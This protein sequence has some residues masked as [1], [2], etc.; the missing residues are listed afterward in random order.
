[1]RIYLV[2]IALSGLLAAVYA[3]SVLAQAPRSDADLARIPVP[4]PPPAPNSPYYIPAGRRGVLT[5][6]AKCAQAVMNAVRARTAVAAPNSKCADLM[7]TALKLQQDHPQPA[8]T[9]PG[10][11]Q[12]SPGPPR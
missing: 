2:I 5:W 6:D 12:P 10:S 4:P 1:M 8:F 11:P 3:G 7:A 9:P